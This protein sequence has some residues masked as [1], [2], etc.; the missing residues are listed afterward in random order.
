MIGF[1]AMR[2]VVRISYDVFYDVSRHITV[3][4]LANRRT[5]SLECDESSLGYQTMRY[6]VQSP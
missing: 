1:N 4:R 5:K 2:M 6:E 3:R